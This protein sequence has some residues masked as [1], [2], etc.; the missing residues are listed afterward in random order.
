MAEDNRD[1]FDFEED[2][3]EGVEDIDLPPA[4]EPP[5]TINEPPL[6]PPPS[7][8]TPP[9]FGNPPSTP[10]PSA[11]PPTSFPPQASPPVAPPDYSSFG[12][13]PTGASGIEPPEQPVGMPPSYGNTAPPGAYGGSMPPPAYG[14]GV[15]PQA[16]PQ[17]KNR[18]CLFWGVIVLVIGILGISGCTAWVVF[19]GQSASDAANDFLAEVEDGDFDGAANLTDPSCDLSAAE[20]EADLGGLTEFFIIGVGPV[21]SGSVTVDEQEFTILFELR[22]DQICSYTLDTVSG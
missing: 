4:F 20:I 7:A 11:D 21:A 14:T 15:G 12:A 6:M 19:S 18:G 8:P 1:P 17:K 5:E 22:D 9:P 2:P 10:P 16:P 13:P 3:L